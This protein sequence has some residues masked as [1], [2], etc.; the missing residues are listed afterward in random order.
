MTL[1]A[2]VSRSEDEIIAP[3]TRSEFYHRRD[4]TR[5]YLSLPPFDSF[6]TIVLFLLTRSLQDFP[7]CCTFRRR[8][9][10]MVHC[11]CV[12]RTLRL[13][14]ASES[15]ALKLTGTRSYRSIRVYSRLKQH[16]HFDKIARIGDFDF[17]L[18]CARCESKDLF[19]LSNQYQ[20]VT[21]F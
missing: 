17:T 12:S 16:V 4:G 21:C 7:R 2:F 18:G 3:Q 9:L 8:I 13:I 10:S 19:R 15:C 11:R 5:L 14:F 1:T 20:T 6:F